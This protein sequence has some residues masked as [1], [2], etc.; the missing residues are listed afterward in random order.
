MLVTSFAV[1]EKLRSDEDEV[2]M[3]F[4][5]VSLACPLGKCRMQLPCRSMSTCSH[6][7]CFDANFFLSMNE[8]R[9]AWVCPVCDREIPFRTLVLDG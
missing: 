9:P 7:Q 3:T 2:A 6:L 8:K 1:K 5:R 4:L